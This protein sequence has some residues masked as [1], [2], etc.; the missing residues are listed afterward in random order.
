MQL[1]RVIGPVV[2]TVKQR[3]LAGRSLLL[4]QPVTPLGTPQ[5]M[6]M[7]AVDTVSAGEGDLVLLLDEGTGAR[8]VM[9]DSTAPVRTVIVG[10]VDDV[11][12]TAT[13][14]HGN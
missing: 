8:Q 2:S 3:A 11:Q 6:Q 5:G 7:I 13:I 9:Q 1:A 14:P 10:I 12:M 4:V